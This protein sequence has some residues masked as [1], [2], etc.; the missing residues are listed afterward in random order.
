[1]NV[2]FL[3]DK[4]KKNDILIS[5]AD[6]EL[7]ISY[8]E[9]EV[10][11]S[12]IPEIKAYKQ[13]IITFL[14]SNQKQKNTQIP[15]T[16]ILQEGYPL[17]SSQKRSWVVS[18]ME[19]EELAY[20]IHSVYQINSHIDIQLFK[21]SFSELLKRHE[22]LRAIY[23][24]GNN[25]EIRQFFIPFE[26]YLPEI[27]IFS[28]IQEEEIPKAIRKLHRK[29]FD[30]KNGPLIRI[31]LIKKQ[32][33][34][35]I[36]FINTHH[37]ISDAK[38]IDI[39]LYDL[40]KIYESKLKG[41][42]VP[43]K[44]LRIQFKDYV[45]WREERLS[46]VD[47]TPHRD[48][49]LS[50]LEGEL[51]IFDLNLG[52]KRNKNKTIEVGTVNRIIENDSYKK[53]TSFCK[54]KNTTP[55][56]VIIAILKLLFYRYSNQR[57]II[58]SF[59][60]YGRYD[61]E[62]ENQIGFYAEMLLLRTQFKGDESFDAFLSMISENLIK[63]YEHR[64]YDFE[65]LLKNIE[66]RKDISR[67]SI[68]DVFVVYKNFKSIEILSNEMDFDVYADLDITFNDHDFIFNFYE[69]G[70]TISCSVDYKIS[71]Y[72]KH[73]IE[74]L[75]LH[76]ETI[77]NFVVQSSETSI[78]KVKLLNPYEESK[79]LD[80]GYNKTQTEQQVIEERS[81]DFSLLFF[82]NQN[83]A[84]HG[85]EFVLE[86]SKY[87]DQAGFKAVW[88]PERHFNE[89]GGAYPNPSVLGAALAV[90]TDQI[91]I[92][93]GSIIAAL[94]HPVRIAEEWSVVDNL[95]QGRVET[96]FASG[97][98]VNDFVIAP[99]NFEDRHAI[100][101]ERINTVKK[102]WR[103]EKIIFETPEEKKAI[104][105]FPKPIQKELPIWLT[106][107]RKESFITAGKIGASILFS[108]TSID[109]IKEKI[110]I[111]RNTCR[112][113]GYKEKDC[114]VAIMLHTYIDSS[115]ENAEMKVLPFL[116]Q[117][118]SKQLEMFGK[119]PY[120]ENY[121][122]DSKN[123]DALLEYS[124]K[125]Y[126]ANGSLIGTEDSCYDMLKNLYD[127]GVDEIACLT[128]FGIEKQDN[129]NSLTFVANLKNKFNKDLKRNLNSFFED[130]DMS[131][132]F[133]KNHTELPSEKTLT[134][135]DA[136]KKQVLETPN[137]IALETG[138]VTLTYS[139]L[140]K[141]SD[142]IAT[143][144]LAQGCVKNDKV[145]ICMSRS[146]M[147]IIA[148]LGIL[149]IGAV[150]VP[151]DLTY[152]KERLSNIIE[153][154]K[155]KIVI[156]DKISN[157]T[158]FKKEIK[159]FDVEVLNSC[160]ENSS[161]SDRSSIK[162]N[163]H[164]T[165]YIIYTSGSTGE[166]VGVEISHLSLVTFIK[167]MNKEV[168]FSKEDKILSATNSVF[169]ISLLEFLIPLC[170][171]GTLLLANDKE[172]KNM[173]FLQKLIIDAKPT[174]M[175]ATPS[176]WQMLI[177]SGWENRRPIK[178]LSGGEKLD[179]VLKDD[180]VKL[181]NRGSIFNLYGPTET[182]IWATFQEVTLDEKV[183]IGKPIEGVSVYILSD[184]L[185]LVPKGI[186]GE[187][188]IGGS[189][190]A[191]RYYEKESLT[192]TRFV[193]NPFDKEERLYKTGDYGRW[194]PNGTIA[195]LGRKDAQV[196]INGNRIELGEVEKRIKEFEGIKD[197][198]V[199]KKVTTFGKDSLVAY[200]KVKDTIDIST[201]RKNLFL[202]IPYYMIPNFYIQLDTFPLTAAGKVD[203][204]GLSLMET[205]KIQ[206]SEY[207]AP[208][209]NFEQKFI[210]LVS[211]LT[212]ESVADIGINNNL[213]DLGLTSLQMLR[214]ENFISE[215]YSYFDFKITMLFDYP[216]IKDL[217]D[218]LYVAEVV[219]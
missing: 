163:S 9:E 196:K 170:F 197:A 213:F 56:S 131:R 70:D 15:K 90:S 121:S 168:N 75:L 125:K 91:K 46:K 66:Y 149:K 89:F 201:L 2:N 128:D 5:V 145:P 101:H 42:E 4:L 162:I 119:L 43:L 212:G 87:A 127:I 93:S 28:E 61:K 40:F 151:M 139:D 77:L 171:G 135:I 49:W 202:K 67:N 136:F 186:M 191:K 3:M 193:N 166:P 72:E 30:L 84:N 92:R 117:Y 37:I 132:S 195:F 208:R 59:P 194:L 120:T 203:I 20:N 134:V 54:Q 94:H 24:E 172:C 41:I 98:N 174:F 68:S 58:I 63:V 173:H 211:I 179:D 62:L 137:S 158:F 85:Y 14:K 81:L 111:Y 188:C 32:Q 12:L 69:T 109:E 50:H 178:I 181:S 25:Q 185:E 26:D 129:L 21:E 116:K 105:I 200:L 159:V 118:F 10:F 55:F 140:D 133:T 160:I 74:R 219:L 60:I 214:I 156:V 96:S 176:R 218:S 182:T 99:K 177:D 206:D 19:T 107:R 126:I 192:K 108:F 115:L 82:G 207:L 187:I 100:M 123:I 71:L 122:L 210:E 164:D 142:Q 148:I 88:T 48:F 95:S 143:Y 209:N 141:K 113:Y 6:G 36:F 80:I 184:S 144:L 198:V 23:K 161:F 27:H 1:M 79:L 16:E 138:S 175:Q 189:Q 153:E 152:P 103:G 102:L 204:R 155:A 34:S 35:W 97:W 190:L 205:K 114:K 45:M 112:A 167:N 86:S 8:L 110:D 44:P 57:D 150:Y 38:S 33:N 65:D 217:M 76:F 18:Q 130:K 106:V 157:A 73:L 17:T 83:S 169:D 64:D 53:F 199:L 146:E 215:E 31:S 180:L 51:P 147:M 22:I 39:L 7:E 13:E 104:E 216:N 47:M 11:K 183:T 165:A 78:D 52:K 154:V 124:A 29:P